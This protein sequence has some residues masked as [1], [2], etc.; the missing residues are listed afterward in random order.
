LTLT[1]DRFVDAALAVE[2]SVLFGGLKSVLQ[3]L[4]VGHKPDIVLAA[5]G[6]LPTHNPTRRRG[7]V[8]RPDADEGVH[9][10]TGMHW[11]TG[12]CVEW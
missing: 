5:Y 9:M 7:R 10:T 8:W 11:E 6:R 3:G 4:A 1:A 12:I 2:L